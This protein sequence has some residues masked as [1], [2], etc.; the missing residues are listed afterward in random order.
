[1]IGE[2]EKRHLIILVIR[3]SNKGRLCEHMTARESRMQIRKGF[4]SF[5]PLDC[6]WIERVTSM[7]RT[8]RRI[9]VY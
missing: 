8:L 5:S 6:T 7:S 1:M 4:P 3:M 9:I 2:V